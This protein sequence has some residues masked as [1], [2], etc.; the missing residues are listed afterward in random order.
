MYIVYICRNSLQ[1]GLCPVV[2]CPC[3]CG[4]DGRD[5]DWA[6][7]PLRSLTRSLSCYVIVCYKLCGMTIHLML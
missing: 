6:Y 5:A 4:S 2:M 1:K 3:L 7:A